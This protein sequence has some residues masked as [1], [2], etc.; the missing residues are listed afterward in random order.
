MSF[1]PSNGLQDHFL[2]KRLINPVNNNTNTT[3]SCV[4]PPPPLPELGFALT[5]IVTVATLEV[6]PSSSLTV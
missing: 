5:V 1:L 4:P 2:L 3:L 6:A